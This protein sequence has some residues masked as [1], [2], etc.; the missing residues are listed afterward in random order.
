MHGGAERHGGG[1]RRPNRAVAAL[2]AAAAA[3]AIAGCSDP[4]SGAGSSSGPSIVTGEQVVTA[5][6]Q[7]YFYNGILPKASAQANCK[8]CV[9]DVLRKLGVD[10]TSGENVADMLTGDRLSSVDIRS[11]Q[12]GCNE[13][14]AN[15]Q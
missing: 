3:L 5:C 15:A 8:S 14:D 4:G 1:R 13:P 7:S 11:L 10:P 12:N 6:F 9:V 2:L